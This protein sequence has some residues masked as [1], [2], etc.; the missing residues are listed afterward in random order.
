[1]SLACLVLVLLL[2]QWRPLPSERYVTGPLTAYTDFLQEHFNAGEVHHGA[3]AWILGVLVPVMLSGFLY[4]L[5]FRLH[6]ALG[7]VFNVGVLYLTMGFR[8]GSHHFT[9]IHTALKEGNNE[10]AREALG[11]WSG[12]TNHALS[13]EEIARVS[14]EKAL[15]GSHRF[16]FGVMFWFILLPGPIGA[17]LYRLSA[18]FHRRWGFM[19]E[20]ELG[21]F[22]VFS[23]QAFR[24]I[25][26]LPAR[27]TALSFAV[28]GDFEDAV[29]CWRTQAARWVDPLLG[30]VLAAGAGALGVR[31]GMPLRRDDGSLEDRIEL[32][33]GDAADAAFLDSTVGLVWRALVLWLA[34]ILLLTIVRSVS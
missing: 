25:D 12:A 7:L 28:V 26:W 18:F 23:R 6:P 21:R 30:I 20:A 3:I 31:L 2:E 8:Q 16:V 24:I 17:V 5:M 4:W 15:A 14:I 33:T 19:P 9:E 27:A 29:Y 11:A 34:L 22:G 10:T 32:G 13:E 1:V